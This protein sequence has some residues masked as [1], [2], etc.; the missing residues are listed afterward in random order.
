MT[1]KGKKKKKLKSISFPLYKEELVYELE[2]QYVQKNFQNVSKNLPPIQN[3]S[4]LLQ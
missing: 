2:K 3:V 4:F 1:F